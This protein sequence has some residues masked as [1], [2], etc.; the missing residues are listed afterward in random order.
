MYA[1]PASARVA[2][3]VSIGLPAYA[4]PPPVVETVGVRPGYVWAPGYWRW[5]GYRYG[6]R[7]GYWSPVRVGYHY[8]PARGVGCGPHWCYHGGGWVR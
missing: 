4:P 8:A 6:W 1:P 5:D 3:G 7:G 2:V